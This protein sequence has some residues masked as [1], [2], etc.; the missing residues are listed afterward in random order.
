MFDVN[1]SLI[2]DVKLTLRNNDQ[3]LRYIDQKKLFD[4]LNGLE[5]YNK[6]Y[7]KSL[8]LEWVIAFV[9]PLIDD[10]IEIYRA[11]NKFK[12]IRQFER[13]VNKPFDYSGSLSYNIVMKRLSEE[14]NQNNEYFPNNKNRSFC[15]WKG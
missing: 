6:S 2:F 14:E 4:Y 9:Y 7:P 15:L 11:T 1:L 10:T 13:L 3:L 12:A 8:G 5:F